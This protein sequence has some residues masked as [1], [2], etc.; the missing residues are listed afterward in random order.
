MGRILWMI[1]ALGFAQHS[2]GF[3]PQ[4]A[5][6]GALGLIAKTVRAA[7]PTLD[8]DENHA[9]ALTASE[10]KAVGRYFKTPKLEEV[11]PGIGRALRRS[12]EGTS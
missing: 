3:Q 11:Y 7:A 4:D 8:D 5:L 10:A 6:Q 1:G 9:D 12:G 2:T